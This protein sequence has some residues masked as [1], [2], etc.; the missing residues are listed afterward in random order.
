[1]THPET[2]ELTQKQADV[3]RVKR[4]DYTSC[5]VAFID[6]KKPGS[7]ERELFDHWAGR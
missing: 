6:C 7:L 2:L 1:M 5:T 4:S 3:R